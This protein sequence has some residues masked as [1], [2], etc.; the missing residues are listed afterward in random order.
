MC[1]DLGSG[2]RI[3][4]SYSAVGILFT[5]WVGMIINSQPFFIAGIEDEDKAKTSAFGAMVM[6]VL[7]FVGSIFGIYHDSKQKGGDDMSPEGAEG[8]QLNIGATEYGSR[9]D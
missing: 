5:F 7:T 1:S 9:L 3:C 8:Y 4:A 2:S 6:F